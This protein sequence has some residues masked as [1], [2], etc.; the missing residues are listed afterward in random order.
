MWEAIIEEHCGYKGLLGSRPMDQLLNY[1]KLLKLSFL[2][3]AGVD[4]FWNHIPDLDLCDLLPTRLIV[5][6]DAIVID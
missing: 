4:S 1:A 6:E 3:D 5:A 2:E